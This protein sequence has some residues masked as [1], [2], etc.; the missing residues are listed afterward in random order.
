MELKLPPAFTSINLASRLTL[1]EASML[2]GIPKGPSVYSPY[3]QEERAKNRQQLILNEMVEQ[4]YITKQEATT[5]QKE[6]S[7]LL[8]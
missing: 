3:L 6:N 8:P 2:A 1:A 5:A 4:G 7:L